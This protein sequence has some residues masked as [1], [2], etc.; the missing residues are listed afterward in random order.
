MKSVSCFIDE[1]G[2]PYGEVNQPHF[3][4]GLLQ[5][6][7]AEGLHE[8]LHQIWYQQRGQVAQPR[9]FEF[10]FASI[11]KDR[12]E[13]HKAVIDAVLG[14]PDVRITVLVIDR[15]DPKVAPSEMFGSTWNAYLTYLELLLNKAVFERDPGLTAVILPD[16]LSRPKMNQ[17]TISACL[18]KY[19][20]V[21]AVV[22]LESHASLM[23]QAIDVITG[24]VLHSYRAAK[25]LP[26]GKA[27]YK[28]EV[29]SHLASRVKSKDLAKSQTKHGLP[30]YFSIWNFIPEQSPSP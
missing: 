15:T 20:Q 29:S 25:G 2:T 22:P 28:A 1:S 8:A 11:T 13:G 6:S 7:D 9:E 30:A 19:K 16:Y 10:K 24:C 14:R 27:N 12:V 5:V 4:L 17:K 3:A 21:A 26:I 23:I 18:E